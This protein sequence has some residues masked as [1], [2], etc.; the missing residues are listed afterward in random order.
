[1][2]SPDVE[3]FCAECLKLGATCVDCLVDEIEDDE[4]NAMTFP[5]AP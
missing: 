1:M 3:D 4:V 2:P 5:E